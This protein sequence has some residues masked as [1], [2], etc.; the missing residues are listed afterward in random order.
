MTGIN[1]LLLSATGLHC[2]PT[3]QLSCCVLF[4]GPGGSTAAQRP[5]PAACSA[6]TWLRGEKGV[7]LTFILGFMIESTYQI[8][9]PHLPFII[10]IIFLQDRPPLSPSWSSAPYPH[11]S[12][13]P[14]TKGK[15]LYL[16]RARGNLQSSFKL[17]TVAFSGQRMSMCCLEGGWVALLGHN[18]LLSWQFGDSAGRVTGVMDLM[19]LL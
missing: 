12:S 17:F 10:I 5:L 15:H 2:K 6:G 3:E 9:A 14:P 1:K 4:L 7:S 8:S 13:Q 11:S 19:V 18:V 16:L